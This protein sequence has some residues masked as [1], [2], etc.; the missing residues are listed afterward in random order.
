MLTVAQAWEAIAHWAS[1][2]PELRVPLA[3]ALGLVLAEPAIADL[4][5]PPFD[6]SLMDGYA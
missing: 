2:L 4:D 6:K 3:E 1:P 5:S